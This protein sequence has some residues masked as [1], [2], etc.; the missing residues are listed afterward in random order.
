MPPLRCPTADARPV[1]R[2]RRG[3]VIAD[4]RTHAQALEMCAVDVLQARRELA[5]RAVADERARIPRELH[6]VIAR[7]IRVITVQA[8]VAAQLVDR[9]PGQAAESL[10]VIERTGREALEAMRRMLLVLRDG[11]PDASLPA[12]RG[13]RTCRRSSSGPAI[14]VSGSRWPRAAA[15]AGSRPGPEL[16]VYRVVQETLTNVVKRAPDS[17]ANLTVT[18]DPG[19]SSSRSLA[20]SDPSAAGEPRNSRTGSRDKGQGLRGTAERAAR[21]TAGP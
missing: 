13:W 7:A 19:R 8:G 9:R 21:C 6:D 15:L 14:P 2:N 4:R 1:R 11:D 5:D 3:A 16:A 20:V 17:R 18:Y 10:G 12:P